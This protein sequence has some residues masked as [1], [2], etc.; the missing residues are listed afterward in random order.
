MS[1]VNEVLR[2]RGARACDGVLG[3][4]ILISRSAII[5]YSRFSLYLKDEAVGVILQ[6]GST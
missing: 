6:G 4:D 5:D 1:H 2:Q 3:A